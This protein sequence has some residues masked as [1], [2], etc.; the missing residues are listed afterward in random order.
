[1]DGVDQQAWKDPLRLRNEGQQSHETSCVNNGGHL[2]RDPRGHA[3]RQ[4]SFPLSVKHHL[5]PPQSSLPRGF[6][7]MIAEMSSS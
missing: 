2:Q 1:M 4:C 3:L 5:S 6:I 7:W